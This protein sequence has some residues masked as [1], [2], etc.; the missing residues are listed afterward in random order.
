MDEQSIYAAFAGE[1]LLAT[2]AL[3]DVLT[4][5]KRWWDQ[6]PGQVVLTFEEATGRQVDFDLRG[7][8]EDVL[9]R[10]KPDPETPAG[11]G[12]PRLG[13][14]AREVTLL[15]R[16]WEWLEQ[17]P[18]GASAALRRLVEQARKQD[19][20]TS[21]RVAAGAACRFL[22]AMAGRLSGYEEATRALYAGDEDRFGEL[23][24]AW[25]TD[26]RSYALRLAGRAFVQKSA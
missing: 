22:S 24:S 12:R 23:T 15:P 18:S 25:P 10:A 1:R 9:A 26:V 21:F 8:V 5:V 7:T 3:R 11:P 4:E 2:G 19:T 16:H 6:H 13:V 20:E 17:Q 14:V